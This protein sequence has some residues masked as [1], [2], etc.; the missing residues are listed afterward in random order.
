MHNRRERNDAERHEYERYRP[1]QRSTPT[2][3]RG[4]HNRKPIYLAGTIFSILFAFPLF[5]LLETRDPTVILLTFIVGNGVGRL[6]QPM[7][8][9]GPIADI[10]GLRG[11]SIERFG[12]R[13]ELCRIPSIVGFMPFS[14]LIGSPIFTVRFE[15]YILV[16]HADR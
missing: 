6:R 9:F 15:R 2:S 16:D 10:D 11:P 13:E 4:R 5:W 8:R 14:Y 7:C 12:F 3:G 1:G